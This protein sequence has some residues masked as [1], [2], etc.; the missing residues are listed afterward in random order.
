MAASFANNETPQTACKCRVDSTHVSLN[1]ASTPGRACIQLKCTSDCNYLDENPP[2]EA[3]TFEVDLV[4]GFVSIWEQYTKSALPEGETNGQNMNSTFIKP[5]TTPQVTYD[6]RY[7]DDYSG[8]D[9]LSLPKVSRSTQFNNPIAPGISSF[10]KYP[11]FML[12]PTHAHAHS[13]QIARCP[14]QGSHEGVIEPSLR[15]SLQKP[16][17]T[18]RATV[19]ATNS[20][21]NVQNPVRGSEDR[22]TDIHGAN[23]DQ[24]AVF[25]NLCPTTDDKDA[26]A[27]LQPSV[28]AL[29]IN[30]D[31]DEVDETLDV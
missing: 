30:S 16:S 31:A 25:I 7:S 3:D 24:P 10:P 23:N 9:L 29:T 28:A 13:S 11:C 17:A 26:L 18:R 15:D 8:Y 22:T 5:P 14:F 4:A 6:D 20:S 27:Q 1:Q 19:L 2:G 21:E 12:R